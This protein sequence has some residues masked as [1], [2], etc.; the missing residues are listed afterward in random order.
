MKKASE[1]PEIIRRMIEKSGTQEPDPTAL[2]GTL[3]RG[4]HLVRLLYRAFAERRPVAWTNV[5]TP[6]ELIFGCDYI[7]FWLDGSGGFSGWIEMT[8]VFD[9]ADATLPTRDICTFLRAAVGGATMEL[10]PPP[11]AVVCTSHLCEGCAK[12]ARI[13][14]RHSHAEFHL[15]DVPLEF[16]DVAVAYVANQLESLAHKLCE[17]AGKDLNLDHLHK[18][19]ELSNE[20][21]RYFLEV[22]ELRKHVPTPATGSQFIGMGLMYPW[23]TQIGVNIAKSLRDE[24]A[25][26]VTDSIPAVPNGEK[27]RLMWLHLRPVFE[28]DIMTHLEQRMGAVIV[29]DLLGEAWWPEMDADEPFRAL[30]MRMLSNPELLPMETKVERLLGIARDYR[31]DGVVHFL[32]WGCR[33]NC[34]QSAIFREAMRQSD[35][36]LLTLDGDAVDKRATP[37]GQVL[38]RIEGFLELLD[39]VGISKRTN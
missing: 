11:T 29:A 26:R 17:L 16:S 5:F 27:Y 28:T 25:R 1:R 22:Y 23:G 4:M 33:W 18:S 36:P 3:M 2:N 13:G 15:L 8:E 38:T 7:P 19:I 9:H 24:V 6:P 12:V 34:G 30:A 21:R 39:S 14:A 20:A 35:I 10:F 32:Q 31:V 37:Y